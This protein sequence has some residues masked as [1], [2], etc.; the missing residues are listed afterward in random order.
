MTTTP[1]M[2]VIGTLCI[3]FSLSTQLA[4]VLGLLMLSVSILVGKLFMFGHVQFA[5]SFVNIKYSF[6]LDDVSFIIF[7]DLVVIN[8]IIWVVKNSKYNSGFV[9]GVCIPPS[10]PRSIYYNALSIIPHHILAYF[11]LS[12]SK[13]C[14]SHVHFLCFYRM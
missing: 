11:F 14:L 3:L 10:H 6:H 1:L 9:L 5:A 4:P 8:N 2:Q 12:I 7:L 13:S